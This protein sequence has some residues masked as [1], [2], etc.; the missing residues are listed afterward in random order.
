M[1][2][3][4]LFSQF[5]YAEAEQAFRNGQISEDQWA[6]YQLIWRNSVPRFSMASNGYELI[7]EN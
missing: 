3:I 2:D 6:E 4:T 1:D 5:T 7:S